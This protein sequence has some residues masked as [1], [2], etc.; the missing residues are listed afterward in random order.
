MQLLYF[1]PFKSNV[2]SLKPRILVIDNIDSFTFNLVQLLESAEQG[3]VDVISYKDIG[4]DLISGYD[5]I[6]ISPGPGVPSEY[7]KLKRLLLHYQNK[8]CFLGVCLGMQVIAE[9]Y[10]LPLINL[11]RVYHGLRT[12]ICLAS[13][14]GY[15]F[16]GIPPQ[17]N[18]GLYHSW[19]VAENDP[20]IFRVTAISNDNIIM[21]MSHLIYDIQG[22]QFHPE[23]YMTE[24]GREMLINWLKK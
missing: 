16:E 20:A 7:P 2:Y 15:L 13:D 24:Y 5:K 11:S 22:V 14:P 6:L 9:V 12:K 21:A 23:S 1:Y 17:F 3:S 8:K 19:A 4:L 10:G 18:A